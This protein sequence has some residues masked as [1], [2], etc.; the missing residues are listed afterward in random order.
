[1]TSASADDLVRFAT[2]L[3]ERLPGT[4]TA[5]V[6]G[7]IDYLKART[8]WHRTGQVSGEVAAEIE[9]WVLPRASRQTTGEIRAKVRR[10]VKLL[11]P[12]AFKRRREAAQR[13]R[14]VTLVETDDGTPQLAGA[15][16]PADGAS[17]AYGRVSAIAAGLKRDGDSRS[18]GQLR[19]DVFLA[20]LRGT[21]TTTAPPADVAARLPADRAD[22]RDVGWSGVDDT[23]A[24]VIAAAVRTE[25]T[26]LGSDLP[27]RH[28]HL[29]PRIAQAA[30]A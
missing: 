23:A 21:L 6:A 28:R 27:D 5:L 3:V 25:L 10:L 29:G 9:A 30:A 4:F 18:I 8:L 7:D 13:R 15:D 11:D 14:E 24:D 12:Q 1:L 26:A 16:L 2:E 19:A 20:L 22:R 17:A